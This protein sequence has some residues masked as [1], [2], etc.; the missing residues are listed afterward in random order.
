MK[1]G[2][3]GGS[4]LEDPDILQEQDEKIVETPYGDVLVKTG[5]LFDVDIVLVSRHGKRHETPP[6]YVNNRANIYALKKENVNYIIA[7][8]ACG[9]LKEE[10]KRGD[11]VILD[12]FIDFTKFRKLSF[13]DKFEQG[14]VHVSLAEPFSNFLREKLIESC[15]EIG[16]SFHNKGC[17]VTIEGPRFSTFAESKMFRMLGADVINMSIAPEA[18][19]AKEIGIEY[20]AIAMS[21]DYDCWKQ[22]EEPVSWTM[23]EKIFKQNSE[24]VLNLILHT[25]KKISNSDE[26]FVKSKIRTIP[27]F[28]KQGIMF[29]D[30]TTLFKD[31]AGLKK[32]IDIFHERY[33]NKNINVVAG[34][35]SRGFILAGILAERL[36]ASFVPIRKKGKLPY[37]KI[38]ETYELEYGTDE[39]EIH[40]D[41]ICPG[42]KVLIIDDLIATGG[43][44]KACVRLIQ[45]LGGNVEEL[46]FIIELPELKGREKLELT[47]Y[48]VFSIVKFEGE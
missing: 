5:K 10:I 46:A 37:E 29:R 41:A 43:T 33:K 16:L 26:K 12:Q 25:V 32:V 28:P 7:T 42:D 48:N 34:I 20:A 45:R 8:T 38:S 36:N 40:K 30:V 3:I 13:Y 11:I 17:V 14:P 1:I 4:G 22:D 35:E 31:P 15:R 24:N 18:I 21:T 23:I 6:S 44:S 39:V 47:G 27:D 2:I 9:S 19:L